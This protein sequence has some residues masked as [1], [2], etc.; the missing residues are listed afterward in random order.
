M[1]KHGVK[2]QSA[3]YIKKNQKLMS[4]ATGSQVNKPALTPAR[5][6][7]GMELTGDIPRWLTHQQTVIHLSTNQRVHGPGVKLTT[8]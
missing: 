8:C 7:R 4:L 2:K 5:Q 6:A 3:D 1:N